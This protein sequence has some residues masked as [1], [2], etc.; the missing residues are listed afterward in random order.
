MIK[1]IES[2]VKENVF[3]LFQESKWKEGYTT[4]RKISFQI[5]SETTTEEK[6]LVYYNLAWVLDQ[7]NQKDM[8]KEYVKIIK[9]EIEKDKEYLSTNEEK[10][11][12]V[13]NLYNY[14]FSEEEQIEDKQKL[15]L[16]YKDKIEYLDQA[17]MAKAD[18]HFIKKDY[19]MV[20][21]LCEVIHNYKVVK[22]INMQPIPDDM[23]KKID[24]VQQRL[25]FRLKEKD[26]KIYEELVDMLVSQSIALTL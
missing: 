25:M 14:L 4:L 6:R 13:L 16:S 7:I 26:S 18:I 10:Y 24:Y 8:A 2:A 5:D 9:H 22:K 17:L 19:E 15:Y 12:M 1:S 23:L 21:E 3:P 20:G 11:L